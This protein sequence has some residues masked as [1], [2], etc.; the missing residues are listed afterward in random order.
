LLEKLDTYDLVSGWRKDRHDKASTVMS[1]KVFNFFAKLF[2]SLRLHDYN[3]GLKAYTRDA[4][5][6]MY[7]YGGMHRFIPIIA[8]QQGFRVTE[9]PVVH[10]ERQFGKSKYARGFVKIFTNL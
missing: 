3:C 8:Y 1:S 5:K 7:L 9:V 6:S 10:D 2:W 4:A